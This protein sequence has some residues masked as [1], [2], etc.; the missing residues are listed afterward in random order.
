MHVTVTLKRLD[1]FTCL[2]AKWTKRASS[3][4]VWLSSTVLQGSISACLHLHPLLAS[5]RFKFGLVY[6]SSRDLSATPRLYSCWM[7]FPISSYLMKEAFQQMDQM[8]VHFALL[9]LSWKTL[10]VQ[11]RKAIQLP[12]NRIPPQCFKYGPFSSLGC[13]L[14]TWNGFTDC[15]IA[16]PPSSQHCCKYCFYLGHVEKLQLNS[17]ASPHSNDG[18][19]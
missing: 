15:A 1:D 9:H 7:T 10:K 8:S 5:A 4:L 13:Q 2:A 11:M 14:F 3:T 17:S 19:I 18:C 12:S 6:S 16:S